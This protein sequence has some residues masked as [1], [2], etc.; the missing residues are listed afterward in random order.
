[1][2]ITC[3]RNLLAIICNLDYFPRNLTFTQQIHGCAAAVCMQMFGL[4]PIMACMLSLIVNSGN[5]L[6]ARLSHTNAARVGANIT[7]VTIF[8]TNQLKVVT[9]SI[10]VVWVCAEPTE[11]MQ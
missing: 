10:M 9:V 5:G 11:L 1:M 6:G 4:A 8:S 3:F 2:G 7:P